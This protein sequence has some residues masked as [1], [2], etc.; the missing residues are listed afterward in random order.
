MET[1]MPL[2]RRLPALVLA[3][4]LSAGASGG[5]M[6]QCPLPQGDAREALASGQ[7]ARLPDAARRAG[8]PVQDVI[9]AELCRSGDSYSYDV[10]A[11]DRAG[12]LQRFDVPAD[13]E[14]RQKR[15]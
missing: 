9:G 14:R 4:L 6:A 8:V 12:K 5:A 2:R 15:R 7:V 3:A 10:T 13:G 11:L 1:E